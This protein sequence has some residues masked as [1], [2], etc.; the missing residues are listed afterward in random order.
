MEE[1]KYTFKEFMLMHKIIKMHGGFREKDILSKP[2][3]VERSE[4]WNHEHKVL[5]VLEAEPQSDGYR[6]GFS[7]D[8][9]TQ[10][11]CG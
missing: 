1:N 4:T 3:T 5:N 8:L 6:H 11:I 7:V 9:I 2:H 10:S